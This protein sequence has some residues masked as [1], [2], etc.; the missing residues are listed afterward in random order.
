VG[1]G[2]GAVGVGVGVTFGLL[3]IDKRDRIGA[4]CAGNQC[5]SE[6]AQLY[7]DAQANATIATVGTVVGVA[8]GAVGGWLVM[9]S[10]HPT[11]GSPGKGTARIGLVP[12]ANGAELGL[13]GSF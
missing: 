2:V 13:G 8:A 4:Q 10:R 9:T 5:S 11:K 7:R 1:L 12:R 3:A 6:G